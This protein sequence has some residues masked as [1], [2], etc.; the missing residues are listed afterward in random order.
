MESFD[1]IR[2]TPSLSSTCR[3]SALTARQQQQQQQQQQPEEEEEEQQQLCNGTHVNNDYLTFPNYA[4]L[5]GF[6]FCGL[7]HRRVL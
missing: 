5:I 4:V 3:G 6:R 2:I 7:P 1:S